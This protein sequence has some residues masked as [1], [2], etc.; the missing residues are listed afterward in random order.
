MQQQSTQPTPAS[1]KIFDG[2]FL[3]AG[4]LPLFPPL[5]EL[6]KLSPRPLI[7]FSLDGG[8]LYVNVVEGNSED[9][10]RLRRRFW[11]GSFDFSLSRVEEWENGTDESSRRLCD[12][13]LP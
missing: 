10:E 13:I 12:S 6:A 1:S 3:Y 8:E 5:V 11:A 7:L 2:L 9:K 4:A